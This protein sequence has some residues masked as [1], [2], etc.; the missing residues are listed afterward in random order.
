MHP[1]HANAVERAVEPAVERD[2][3]ARFGGRA[4]RKSCSR[5]ARLEVAFHR[6]TGL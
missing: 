6:R 5:E 1:G 3:R 2:L 4:E